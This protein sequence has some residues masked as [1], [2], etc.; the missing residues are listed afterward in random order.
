MSAEYQPL[1]GEHSTIRKWAKEGKYQLFFLMDASLKNPNWDIRLTFSSKNPYFF[2]NSAK[3]LEEFKLLLPDKIDRWDY[4]VKHNGRISLGSLDQRQS[5][6]E[7]KQ[8]R[9]A[10]MAA[11]GINFSSQYIPLM[12]EKFDKVSEKWKEGQWIEFDEEMKIL[13]YYYLKDYF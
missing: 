4:M 3:A 11:I 10:I 6:K 12:L 9:E 5:D 2:L 1:L 8:R 7:W 13:K